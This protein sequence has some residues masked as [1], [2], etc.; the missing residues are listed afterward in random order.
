LGRTT[1]LSDEAWETAALS[2]RLVFKAHRLLYHSS[3]GLRVIQ[4]K[5]RDRRAAN[6][7][8]QGSG[9]RVSG[10]E[11]WVSGFRERPPSRVS[12]S[13][14]CSSSSL[15]LSSLELSDTKVYEL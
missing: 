13:A 15:L 1:L 14:H 11:F 12:L 10:F 8:V 9:F 3:V 7:R 4:K 2:G 6:V 5:R